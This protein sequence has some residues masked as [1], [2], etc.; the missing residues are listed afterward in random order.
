[1]STTENRVTAAIDAT[2]RSL[3]QSLSAFWPA[4]GNNEMAEAN[5]V[6]HL[7]SVLKREGMYVY[8]EVPLVGSDSR[9]VDMVAFN[10][11]MVIAAEAKRLYS[12]EKAN[13]MASDYWRLLDGRFPVYDG[14]SRMPDQVGPIVLILQRPHRT[15]PAAATSGSTWPRSDGV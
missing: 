12:S 7:A 10:D 9:H 15:D 14:G 4:M 1:M 13:E 2:A 3:R 8:A 6:I 11:S 5:I